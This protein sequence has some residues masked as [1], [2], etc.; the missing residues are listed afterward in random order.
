MWPQSLKVWYT[1]AV[2]AKLTPFRDVLAATSPGGLL[3]NDNKHPGVLLRPSAVL[4]RFVAKCSHGCFP[5]FGYLGPAGD[6]HEIINPP[7]QV[8]CYLEVIEGFEVTSI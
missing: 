7:L 8:E 1:V 6:H 2:A 3:Y 5:C 4:K